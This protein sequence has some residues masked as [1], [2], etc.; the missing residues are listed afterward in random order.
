MLTMEITEGD[1]GNCILREL[2]VKSAL[3]YHESEMPC[4][5]DVNVYRGCGHGCRYCFAQYS[6]DYLGA[7]NFFGEI[8]VKENVA[9]VLDHELSRRKWQHARINL[10]GVTD[11]YQPVEAH[12][13]IMPEIWKV[14]I[15]HRNPVVITTKSS[16]ILRDLDL[17][18]EL[19]GLTN[20]YVG[21]TITMLDEDL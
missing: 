21:A 2:T 20:V 7:G 9:G 4:N 3:H 19:A 16:L 6:H 8:F 18:K 15:R 10:S 12:R 5:W 17:I 14:L 13:N 1:Y 11:A